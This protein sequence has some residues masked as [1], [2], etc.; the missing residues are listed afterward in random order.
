MSD[1]S[2]KQNLTNMGLPADWYKHQPVYNCSFKEAIKRM[3]TKMF[4]FKGRASRAEYW[5]SSIY[6][7]IELGIGIVLYALLKIIEIILLHT[8]NYSM[9]M[10][11]TSLFASQFIIILSYLYFAM[12]F[13]SII[14]S[15]SLAVRRLHDT[16]APGWLLIFMMLMQVIPPIGTPVSIFLL[17]RKSSK[18]GIKYDKYHDMYPNPRIPN[19][20][21]ALSD[22][23]S[24]FIG[25]KNIIMKEMINSNINSQHNGNNTRTMPFNYNEHNEDE[26]DYDFNDED[27]DMSYNASFADKTTSRNNM[28]ASNQPQMNNNMRPTMNHSK[29]MHASNA[30]RNTQ[31]NSAPNQMMN[32]Q[33][34]KN[35]NNIRVNNANRNVN[36][37]RTN[38]TGA[39]RLSRARDAYNNNP[40]PVKNDEYYQEQKRKKID[41][42]YNNTNFTLELGDANASQVNPQP[43]KPVAS[44]NANNKTAQNNPNNQFIPNNPA[45][46]N[47]IRR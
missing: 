5:L 25:M 23:I 11:L 13:I 37:N 29:N 32:N 10:M 24:E 7:I 1:N 31:I 46:S 22:N 6:Y 45:N 17:A 33:V 30:S 16:N 26:D 12:F 9:Y 20:M 39:G 41:D 27:D 14:P 4:V 43:R 2:I 35:A 3:F 8:N 42:L 15:V 34:N 28:R 38:N 40:T 19:D 44:N 36:I 18:D 47:F 21:I